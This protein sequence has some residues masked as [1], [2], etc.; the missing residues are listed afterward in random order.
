MPLWSW[1]KHLRGWPLTA[2]TLAGAFVYGHSPYLQSFV[3][4]RVENS[5]NQVRFIPH[6]AMGPLHWSDLDAF[7]SFLPAGKT[8]ADA[9]EFLVPMPSRQP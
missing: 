4:I 6:G 3:E 7:G 5:K 1:V 9:L 8:G 2:E